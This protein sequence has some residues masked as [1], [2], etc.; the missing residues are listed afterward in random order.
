LKYN[1]ETYSNKGPRESNQDRFIAEITNID[2]V[3]AAI[4]DGV[5]G[6]NH[7]E[8]SADRAV[9]LF[10]DLI[11]NSK[12][13][14]LASILIK[15]HNSIFEEGNQN[16]E[17]KGMLTTLSACVVSSNKLWFGHVGD[18]RI[19]VINNNQITRL[20]EDH[21]EAFQLV[22]EGKLSLDDLDLYPR[23]NVLTDAIGMKKTPTIQT[24]THELQLGDCIL[25]TSDGVHGIVDD[26]TIFKLYKSSQNLVEFRERLIRAVNMGIPTDNNTFV[27]I[28][29]QS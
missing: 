26:K 25:M 5:G 19:Y 21:S 3:A 2:Y 29:A 27:C 15:I 22:K 8:I 17:L 6:S 18:T 24:G 1:I 10:I 4:A 23:K 13:R 7:G 16:I 12:K 9:N 20:T 28:Q 14:T 11:H